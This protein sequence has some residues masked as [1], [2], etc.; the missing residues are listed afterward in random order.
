MDDI[1]LTC[2]EPAKLIVISETNSYFCYEHGFDYHRISG[3]K[4]LKLSEYKFHQKFRVNLDKVN[5]AKS[6]LMNISVNLINIIKSITKNQLI[7]IEK[8]VDLMNNLVKERDLNTDKIDEYGDIQITRDDL[9]KFTEIVKEYLNVSIN[10]NNA[11]PLN[12]DEA[13]SCL[14]NNILEE[15]DKHLSTLTD[16]ILE[17]KAEIMKT[18]NNTSN[19]AYINPSIIVAEL[20][21]D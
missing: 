15:K 10:D 7:Q 13:T 18:Y 16:E 11:F 5:K 2:R 12:L 1:C 20:E 3:N 17:F 8:R 4:L 21:T 14:K 9:N 6:D 19:D